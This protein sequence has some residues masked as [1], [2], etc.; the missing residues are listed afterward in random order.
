MIHRDIKPANILLKD[1][2]V[3]LADFGFSKLV[4]SNEDKFTSEV[5]FGTP[6]YMSPQILNNECYGLKA[7][8]WSAGVVFFEILFGLLPWKGT[9]MKTLYSNII[10]TPP[11]FPSGKMISDLTKDLLIKML[12]VDESKRIDWESL[13]KHSAFLKKK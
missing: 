11:N 3:K 4:S 12:T 6:N 5:Q 13:L 7:D 9:D 10:S 1:G 2:V 8:V